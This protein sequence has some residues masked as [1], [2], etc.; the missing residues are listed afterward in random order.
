VRSDSSE[1]SGILAPIQRVITGDLEGAGRTHAVI[2]RTRRNSST[3]PANTK[4]SPGES[5]AMND[6]ST[7]PSLRPLRS[8]TVMLESETIVPICVR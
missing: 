3:R 7:C 6:S 8:C 1:E 2:S 5:I 4:Q